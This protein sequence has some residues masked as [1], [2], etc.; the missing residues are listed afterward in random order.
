MSFRG[1]VP[2]T[3]IN[4][5]PLEYAPLLASWRKA[6]LAL[7][8]EGKKLWWNFTR[9]PRVKE[10]VWENFLKNL[11]R[12]FDPNQP[13][14][15]IP[16]CITKDMTLSGPPAQPASALPDRFARVV[17][18]TTVKDY[19]ISQ[20][21]LG[22]LW[23]AAQAVAAIQDRSI[24]EHLKKYIEHTLRG[25]VWVGGEKEITQCYEEMDLDDFRNHLGLFFLK[26]DDMPVVMTFTRSHVR[27]KDLG[28]PLLVPTVME[29]QDY[30][31]FTPAD[32]SHTAS[33]LL[34]DLGSGQET[35]PEWVCEKISTAAGFEVLPLKSDRG[36]ALQLQRKPA[37]DFLAMYVTIIN[38]EAGN[39]DG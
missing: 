12:E 10:S 36:A 39:G 25:L 19:C 33:G 15:S 1:P 23:T 38:G 8:D 30:C 20:D 14:D 24:L 32:S 29:G 13:R 16:K 31:A 26:A 5:P 11:D 7:G 3:M 9:E 6:L 27:T 28:N 22:G 18:L 4:A 35:L 21:R 2:G 34:I 17:S 37:T